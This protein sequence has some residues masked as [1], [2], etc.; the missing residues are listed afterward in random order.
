MKNFNEKLK[1]AI[2]IALLNGKSNVKNDIAKKLWKSASM[3]VQV[4]NMSRLITGKKPFIKPE[5]ISIICEET[6]VD[7]NFLFNIN[8]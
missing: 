1:D 7:A 5:W 3:E 8:L 2:Q 4:Q 6:G